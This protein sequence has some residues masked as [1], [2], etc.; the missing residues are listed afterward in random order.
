[1]INALK[2]LTIRGEIRTTVEYIIKLLQADDFVNNKIDTTWLDGRI[3]HHKEVA[4]I[5]NAK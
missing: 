3:E 5:E 4:Q 2:E 1:M